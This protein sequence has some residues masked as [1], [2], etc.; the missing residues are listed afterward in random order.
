MIKGKVNLLVAAVAAASLLATVALGVY[1]WHLHGQLNQVSGAADETSIK[2]ELLDKFEDVQ[3][4]NATNSQLASPLDPFAGF[5]GD[6]FATMQQMQQQMDELFKSATG[7]SSFSFGGNGF[8][9]VF[10]PLQQPE[11]NVEESD[12]EYRI[13]ISVAKG[14]DV[15]LSTD[16]ENNTLSISAEVRS[17]Q[18]ASNGGMQS[19]S[20][21][22]SQ[23]S[24]SIMLDE[25]VDAT[26]MQTRKSDDEIV[27]SIPKVG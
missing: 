20:T 26:G 19:S 24:R 16:L 1:T 23:F 2:T 18:H 6:P 21:S 15:D 25:P 5:A 12:D 4:Q 13:V 17:E 10:S 11:I 9:R 27:I 8:G 3:D 14:T 22:M 7:G